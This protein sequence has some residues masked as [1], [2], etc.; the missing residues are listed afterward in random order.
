MAK[1]RIV[2]VV[3]DKTTEEALKDQGK[4]GAVIYKTVNI[5]ENQDLGA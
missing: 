3:R 2:T 5:D 4:Y 1:D